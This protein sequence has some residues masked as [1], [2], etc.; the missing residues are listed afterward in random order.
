MWEQVAA[1]AQVGAT[2]GAGGLVLWGIARWTAVVQTELKN[3]AT[4]I[5][6]VTSALK[7][8]EESNDK[9][10]SKLHGR[11]DDL[12][13]N[14]PCREQGEKLGRLNG[15]LEAHLQASGAGGGGGG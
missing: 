10:H 5:A 7:D 15:K 13:E 6:G 4:Q 2:L 8:F 1:W 11:L 12:K 14:L 9:G 3:H